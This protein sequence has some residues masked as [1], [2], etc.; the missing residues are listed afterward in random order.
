MLPYSGTRRNNRIV[1]ARWLLGSLA[2]PTYDETANGVA[3]LLMLGVDW[4]RQRQLAALAWVTFARAYAI[5]PEVSAELRRAYYRAVGDTELT[6][7]N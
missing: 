6:N 1:E 2:A 3:G 7:R 5:P 4:L